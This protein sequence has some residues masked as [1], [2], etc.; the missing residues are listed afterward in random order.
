M[1]KKTQQVYRFTHDGHRCVV[2]VDKL[3]DDTTF[4]LNRYLGDSARTNGRYDEG[5]AQLGVLG[6][7]IS[8][9]KID[10]T[11]FSL[12]KGKRVDRYYDEETGKT[13][14]EHALGFVI[15]VN[16]FL[17]QEERYRDAFEE[18]VLEDD[19][20]WIY[21]DDGEEGAE[22]ADSGDGVSL[23]KGSGGVGADPS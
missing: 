3:P 7:G 14:L 21:G 17:V 6:A 15:R 1:A 9:L 22:D 18:Y 11:V 8:K 4:T 23:S 5:M 2:W 16:P 19:T 20:D 10:E 12:T 13:V